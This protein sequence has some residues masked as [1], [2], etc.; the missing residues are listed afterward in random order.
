MCRAYRAA[1]VRISPASLA[2]ALC[3]RAGLARRRVCLAFSCACRCACRADTTRIPHASLAFRRA[4][5]R[6]A[7]LALAAAAL[8]LPQRVASAARGQLAASPAASLAAALASPRLLL[9]LPPLASPHPHC[10]AAAL[11]CRR[12]CCC[13]CRRL[14]HPACLAPLAS[15]HLPRGRACHRA[16]LAVRVAALAS[17]RVWPRLPPRLPR[18]ACRRA[19]LAVH[20]S[21]C[22]VSCHRLHRT[23]LASLRASRRA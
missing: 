22:V 8:V 5:R 21:Q 11:A 16:C 18:R 7:R 3:R 4:A 1:S 2:D 17:P 13:A 12:A 10:L 15:P 20:A 14:P 6:H 9:R 19:C 23:C